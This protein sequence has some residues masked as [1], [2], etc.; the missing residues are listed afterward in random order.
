[1]QPRPFQRDWAFRRGG[2]QVPVLHDGE[3][4]HTASAC[5]GEPFE[6]LLHSGVGLSNLERE[7][8]LAVVYLSNCLPLHIC[9]LWHTIS[10]GYDRPYSI[11]A[12]A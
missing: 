2:W 9:A 5:P 3:T 4:S 7:E 8:L 10:D 12:T 11:Q 6:T 1:M